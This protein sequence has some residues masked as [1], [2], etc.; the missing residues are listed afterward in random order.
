MLPYQDT[1]HQLDLGPQ[2]E[3]SF[4]TVAPSAPEHLVLCPPEAAVS[5]GLTSSNPSTG[6]AGGDPR[7][8]GR[9]VWLV[10]CKPLSRST[11]RTWH[12]SPWAISLPGRI[13]QPCPMAKQDQFLI[14]L[15]MAYSLGVAAAGA[16]FGFE[17]RWGLYNDAMWL[18]LAVLVVGGFASLSFRRM[19]G[20]PDNLL[21]AVSHD[22]LQLGWPR[23]RQGLPF[24]IVLPIFISA[25]TSAKRAI[26]GYEWD[27]TFVVFDAALHGADAWQLIEPLVASPIATLAVNF[28][29][30]LWFP[31]VWGVTIWQ[32][33]SL[34]PH[35]GRYLF[36]FVLIWIVAGTLMAHA[37]ASAGP[38]FLDAIHGDQRFAPLMALLK[39]ANETVPVPALAA[40]HYLL[41]S[42][43]RETLGIGTGISAMP[44]L[45]VAIATLMALLGWKLSRPL[46]AALTAF[47]V[48]IMI[49]SV[50]LGW[51]YAIDGYVGAAVA[52]IIWWLVGYF[53]HR[54]APHA[55]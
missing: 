25:F 41:A 38:C 48:L 44:S 12:L 54:V 21:A 6:V 37:F 19:A 31:V 20:K 39:A 13:G 18:S 14:G 35:R 24:F 26:S 29:Y 49:G 27:Q 15:M 47:A 46:G 16:W 9:V 28:I 42:Y 4:D 5:A 51:H 23:L 22:C 2:K 7:I 10:R 52:W 40:Q 8:I 33:F 11:S 55:H 36:S 43:Q 1:R 30:N 45:H 34:G 32:T 50:Q 53:L 17:T 3:G